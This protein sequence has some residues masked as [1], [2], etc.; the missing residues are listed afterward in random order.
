M[1]FDEKEKEKRTDREQLEI[2]S[3]LTRTLRATIA[4]QTDVIK[5]A[6]V[7]IAKDRNEIANLRD[8]LAAVRLEAG[9]HIAKLERELANLRKAF[10]EAN[11][12]RAEAIRELC[13]GAGPG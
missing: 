6:S 11:R 4:F 5:N 8:A 13:A 3:N 2:Y 1:F 9:A 12:Q 10:D 7:T